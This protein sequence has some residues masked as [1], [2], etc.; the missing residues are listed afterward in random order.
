MTISLIIVYIAVFVVGLVGNLFVFAVVARY[1]SMRT[2]TYTFLVNLAVG[3]VMVVIICMPMTL[4]STV[5]RLW[6]Y[7]D[8]MCRLTPFIQG[9]SVSVSVLTLLLVSL[10]RYYKIY[11]PMKARAIFCGRKVRAMV[12]SVWAAS[13]VIMSPMLAVN[14]AVTDTMGVTLCRERFP[15][16]EYKRAFDVI[17]F[18]ILYVLP[19]AFMAFTYARISRTLWHGD[20][21]LRGNLD[22]SRR[23]IEEQERMRRTKRKLVKM[24]IAIS[25][26]FAVTWLPYHVVTL[27]LDFSRQGVDY[28]HNEVFIAL[29]IYPLVQ[30]LALSNSS[31]N[32]I[33]YCLFSQKF[34]AALCLLCCRGNV[35]VTAAAAAVIDRNESGAT[36]RNDAASSSFMRR[37]M[38]RFSQKVRRS[39]GPTPTRAT[40]AHDTVVVTNYRP[41]MKSYSDTTTQPHG[42]RYPLP[43]PRSLTPASL[44]PASLTPASL[45]PAPLTP[46]FL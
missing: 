34:R 32:P 37:S 26:I 13:L 8:V 4:G 15:S 5:Y 35:S 3:D 31:V 44:T 21:R 20:A 7:G 19:V 38:R 39:F 30:W 1:R 9:V 46:A 14:A 36:E 28:Q 12:V 11:Y 43:D 41:V 23:Q 40:A 29:R 18:A 17:V 22:D 6:I 2:V 24:I 16:I 42:R 27:W 33:C 45:T 10:D 25:V